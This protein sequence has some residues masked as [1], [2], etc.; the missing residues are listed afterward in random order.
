MKL[1]CFRKPV[2]EC[3]QVIFQISE[4]IFHSVLRNE[5]ISGKYSVQ[6]AVK[7]DRPTVKQSIFVLKVRNSNFCLLLELKYKEK[8]LDIVPKMLEK[9]NIFFYKCIKY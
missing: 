6:F 2:S 3:L 9:V 8:C 5:I 4:W 7:R 1:K